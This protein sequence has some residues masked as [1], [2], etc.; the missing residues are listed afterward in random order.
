MKFT[1]HTYLSFH[2]LLMSMYIYN[3]YYLLFKHYDQCLSMFLI[4]T[5][6]D[7]SLYQTEMCNTIDI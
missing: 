5:F 2:I 6:S 3:S 4:E 1:G 7:H